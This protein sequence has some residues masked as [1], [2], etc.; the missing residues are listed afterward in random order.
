LATTRRVCNCVRENKTR[1][2]RGR[3]GLLPPLFA[4]RRRSRVSDHV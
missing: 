3:I 2:G 4:H 1:H